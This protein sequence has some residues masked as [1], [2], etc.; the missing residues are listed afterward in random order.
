MFNYSRSISSSRVIQ[1]QSWIMPYLFI[2]YDCTACI[3]LTFYQHVHPPHSPS[4][5]E[6]LAV[7]FGVNPLAHQLLG[8]VVDGGCVNL[9]EL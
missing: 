6:R 7:A 9:I 1:Q 8:Q 3:I 2:G 5:C 4:V